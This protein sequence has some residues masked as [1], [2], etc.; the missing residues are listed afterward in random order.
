[1]SKWGGITMGSRIS[2][3]GFD[4]YQTIV[5][6]KT[7]LVL[8]MLKDM[9]G[10]EVFFFA[11]RKFFEQHKYSAVRSGSFFRAM[12]D[13]AEMDLQQ[14]FDRWFNSHLLPDV[15]VLYTVHSDP[16]GFRLA[17][18]ILQVGDQFVFPLWIEWLEGEEKVRQ[19]VLV[20]SGVTN[21]EF[22]LKNEPSKIKINPDKSV[23]GR[24]KVT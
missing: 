12:Q 16:A 8:N 11:V 15:R 9:L 7:S 2:Y 18:K 20:N 23:P 5:Y 19:K 4:A 22:E 24:F 1:M 6:N 3:H 21:V 17:V 14:F 13:V 10:D